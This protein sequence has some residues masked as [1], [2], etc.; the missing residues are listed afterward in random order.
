MLVNIQFSSTFAEICKGT[1]IGLCAC[2]D[3]SIENLKVKITLFYQELKTKA[4]VILYNGKPLKN[5]ETLDLVGVKEGDVIQ[6]KKKKKEGLF[7]CF[8]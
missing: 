3:E 8:Y 7:K 4:L 2:D 1:T 6:V 5:G